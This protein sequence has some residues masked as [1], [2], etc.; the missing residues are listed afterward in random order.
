MFAVVFA[1]LGISSAAQP[2]DPLAEEGLPRPPV[3]DTWGQ[4]IGWSVVTLG[5]ALFAAASLCVAIGCAHFLVTSRGPARA[6]ILAPLVITG[7]TALLMV[8]LIV[9]R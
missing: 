2:P 8:A 4:V 9:L 6:L 7:A 1:Y 3:P 5:I